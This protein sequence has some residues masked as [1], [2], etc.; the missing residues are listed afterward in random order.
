MKEDIS[1]IPINKLAEK[2]MMIVYFFIY[3]FLGWILESIYCVATLGVFQKRGFLYGPICP[4]YGIGAV[5]LIIALRKIKGNT[6]VKFFTCMI[7]FSVFE[8]F[9]SFLLEMLFGL[10]W[11]DYSNEFLN[12][13]GRVSL[14]FS[15]A[16]GAIGV[17]FVEKLHPFIIHKIQQRILFIPSKIQ[18]SAISFLSVLLLIDTV[19]SVLKYLP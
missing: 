10:R 2:Q 13:Q 18:I 11:W 14:V 1:L 4:I 8:Y 19:L 5:L 12:I 15:I 7:V 3:A 17:F 6:I 16:W 9:V